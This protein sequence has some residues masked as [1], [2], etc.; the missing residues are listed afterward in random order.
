MIFTIQ[1]LAYIAV[2]R[3]LLYSMNL[4]ELALK[5]KWNDFRKKFIQIYPAEKKYVNFYKQMLKEHL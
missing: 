4:K 1:L 5:Y 3:G 2:L